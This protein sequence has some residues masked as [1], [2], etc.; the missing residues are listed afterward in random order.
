MVVV[1]S[2]KPIDGT[3]TRNC[4]STPPCLAAQSTGSFLAS[5][6]TASRATVHGIMG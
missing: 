1:E 3:I 2:E 6:Q 4:V 5:V